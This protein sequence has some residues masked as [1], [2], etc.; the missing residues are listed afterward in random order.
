VIIID[1]FISIRMK[2][3]FIGRG[4]PRTLTHGKVYETL[5]IENGW[6]RIVDDSGED[7]LYPPECFEIAEER[8]D[9]FV[10]RRFVYPPGMR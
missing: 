9:R 6:Y 3:R 2:V 10:W 5:S 1:T 4:S 8:L 7:Y